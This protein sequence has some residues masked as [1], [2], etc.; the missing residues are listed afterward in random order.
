VISAYNH[1]QEPNR[2]LEVS[3]KS[4]Q[5]VNKSYLETQIPLNIRKEVVA[6]INCQAKCLTACKTFHQA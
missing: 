2:K 4:P 5:K 3:T 6:D 1:D